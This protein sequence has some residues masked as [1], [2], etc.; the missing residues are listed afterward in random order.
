MYAFITV[1][2]DRWLDGQ[3]SSVGF[4]FVFWNVKATPSNAFPEP[5][6]I[7]VTSQILHMGG[8]HRWE[9]MNMHMHMQWKWMNASR[10]QMHVE[11][12]LWV[13][14][15]AR[16]YGPNRVCLAQPSC[17]RRDDKSRREEEVEMF[18]SGFSP[19]LSGAVYSCRRTRHQ[20]RGERYD[21]QQ[22]N[23]VEASHVW[24]HDLTYA[25]SL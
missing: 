8:R 2:T 19:T 3:T 20:G 14:V 21:V 15:F 6:W 9:H 7:I 11:T 12:R 24:S 17:Q 22:W 16:V 4:F 10:S 23:Q 18:F 25:A 5:L 13:S 1:R